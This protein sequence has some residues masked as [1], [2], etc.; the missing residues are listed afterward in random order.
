MS[1]DSNWDIQRDIIVLRRIK[2]EKVLAGVIPMAS[3]YWKIAVRINVK[4]F[5]MG[6]QINLEI[7]LIHCLFCEHMYAVALSVCHVAKLTTL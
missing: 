3:F 2:M 5:K 1:C 4:K 7:Q 6:Q